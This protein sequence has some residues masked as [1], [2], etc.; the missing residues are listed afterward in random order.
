VS[1]LQPQLR[2]D[3][4]IADVATTSPSGAS[5]PP[6][7]GTTP[8][9]RHSS[10][11][12]AICASQT[13]SANIVALR[14]LWREPRTLNEISVITGLPVSS[15]CSLKAALASELEFVDFERITWGD[16]RKATKRSRWR[17]KPD[18]RGPR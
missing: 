9:S 8:Q 16:G 18:A 3:A 1:E 11:T 10:Y 2:F 5:L 4:P 14:Q 13:R 7:N 6:I 15:V 17:I 12:G